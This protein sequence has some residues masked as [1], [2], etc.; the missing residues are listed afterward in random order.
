MLA[1][2][3]ILRIASRQNPRKIFSLPPLG[4]STRLF[5]LLVDIVA[6]A[7]VLLSSKLHNRIDKIMEARKNYRS[8]KANKAFSADPKIQRVFIPLSAAIKLDTG[9]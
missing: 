7:Q 5:E 4:L 6:P 3:T 8:P 9:L 2:I 1:I